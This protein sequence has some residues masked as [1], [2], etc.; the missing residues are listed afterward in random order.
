MWLDSS[1]S[2]QL[3]FY[4]YG[5]YSTLNVCDYKTLLGQTGVKKDDRLFKQSLILDKYFVRFCKG[6]SVEIS[7]VF[8]AFKS[9]NLPKV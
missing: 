6:F 2:K 7:S 4:Q 5:H 1:L 8:I 3:F 9:E